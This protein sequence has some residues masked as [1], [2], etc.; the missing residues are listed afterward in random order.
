[1]PENGHVFLD[2]RKNGQLT[3]EKLNRVTASRLVQRLG[4]DTG[5]YWTKIAR[6][7]GGKKRA[8]KWGRYLLTI[9]DTTVRLIWQNGATL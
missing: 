2:S 6:T 3:D 9:A 7:R 1:M 8:K 5:F 4:V